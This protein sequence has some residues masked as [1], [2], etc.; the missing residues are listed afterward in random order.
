[1]IED[2]LRSQVAR[3][4]SALLHPEELKRIIELNTMKM[5]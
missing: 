4:Q 3:M 1:L 5:Q 2:G